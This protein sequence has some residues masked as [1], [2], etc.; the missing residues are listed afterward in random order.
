MNARWLPSL[1]ALQWGR[2][3]DRHTMVSDGV[4]AL[5]VTLM[6]IPQS[7]AYAQLAGLPPEVGL[8]ASVAPLLV[9]A[10]LGTSRV[11]A[12][13]PVAVVSLMTAAAVGEH[14]AP[15]SG[16]YLAVAITLA[17]LSGGMLL[18]MGF[19]R[20]GFLAN[21]LSHPVIAGFIAASGLLIAASQLKTLLG[22]QAGGHNFIELAGSLIA[23][24]GNT[25]LLTLAIGGGSL[26]FLFWVRR[27]LKPLL[28]RLGLPPRAADRGANAGPVHF[29]ADKIPVRLGARHLHQRLAHAITN[30]Q[31]PW[32]IAAEHRLR[33]EHTGVTLQTKARPE[34]VQRLLLAGGQ[35]AFTQ[36]EAAYLAHHLAG[37][38][39]LVLS[40]KIEHGGRGWQRDAHCTAIFETLCSAGTYN[41][42]PECTDGAYADGDCRGRHGRDRRQLCPAETDRGGRE[43]DCRRPSA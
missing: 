16:Q 27:G 32:R 39:V 3:I 28:M 13:G 11:L 37:E 4:A 19:L 14:A 33:V 5:I 29:D 8:Y 38:R 43:P 2:Q 31:H 1:P 42:G 22:V 10:L 41:A 25:H 24:L 34:I 7:L 40:E 30:L 21:F 20:L 23:Q 6:L 18:V 17:F 26:V 9:Y 36:D 35:A 15:G 12:V